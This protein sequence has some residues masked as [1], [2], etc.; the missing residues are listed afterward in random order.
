MA[1]RE[2]RRVV[3]AALE[4]KP[5]VLAIPDGIDDV[6]GELAEALNQALTTQQEGFAISTI[7]T[8]VQTNQN[9]IDEEE[10]TGSLSM[11]PKAVGSG[12][13][14]QPF[15]Q[16]LRGSGDVNQDPDWAPMLR[17]CGFRK[18][19]GRS[20]SVT[21]NDG[22]Q[23][24]QE[25]E[26]IF[27]EASMQLGSAA[28]LDAQ[29]GTAGA[30]AAANQP[31]AGWT[32][33]AYGNDLSRPSVSG[34]IVAIDGAT[35]ALL[36]NITF[37]DSDG[38]IRQLDHI[39]ATNPANTAQVA[40]N[41]ATADQPVGVILALTDVS[42]TASST[43]NYIPLSAVDFTNGLEFTAHTYGVRGTVSGAPSDV[44]IVY[45]P[46]SRQS[47]SVPFNPWT[48]DET[49]IADLFLG[50]RPGQEVIIFNGSD[51]K[52]AAQVVSLSAD[53][54]TISAISVGANTDLTVTG[55]GLPVN[56]LVPL[57]RGFLRGTS[58]TGGTTDLSDGDDIY[59]I[60]VDANTLR[61]VNAA[62]VSIDTSGGTVN[63]AGTFESP[64]F[65]G[66]MELQPHYG[67]DAW[68]SGAK[69]LDATVLTAASGRIPS[70]STVSGDPTAAETPSLSML[71]MLDGFARWHVGMRGDVG[72]EVESGGTGKINY[73]FQGTPLREEARLHLENIT[74]PAIVPPRWVKPGFSKV[75]GIKVRTL[76]AN[77]A[78]GN[79]VAAE[80]DANETEGIVGYSIT[81]RAPT[82][83]LTVQ[84][85]GHAGFEWENAMRRATWRSWAMQVGNNAGNRIAL[86]APRLQI[87]GIS[88]GNSNGISTV[89][90]TAT[91]NALRGDDE[92]FIY[93]Y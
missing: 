31:A 89:Q 20:M 37:G 79:T 72:F 44:G 82:L 64:I 70:S 40:Y 7:D 57:G 38:Y 4:S 93:S 33:V 27:G 78:M 67:A 91:L 76:S 88:D 68:E 48:I 32:I 51:W 62:K 14:V 46:T 34:T 50:P 2:R 11:K 61:V 28:W 81:G 92:L 16:R 13:R 77:I 9:T 15:S 36:V 60:A 17:A 58:V 56:G 41:R 5:G 80:E 53:S 6:D 74:L 35:G 71:D 90:A 22:Q 45:R 86:V 18:E 63:T 8:S 54:R 30:G 19:V 83:T 24:F 3:L 84:R 39:K 26:Q 73:N 75:Q 85:S 21:K 55:H 59:V 42:G 65:G 25:G 69:V 29:V 10:L 12:D 47:I 1:N 23:V 49:G 87:T 52:A 66:S 43:I